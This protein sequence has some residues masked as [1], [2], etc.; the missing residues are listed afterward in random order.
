MLFIPNSCSKKIKR[1]GKKNKKKKLVEQNTSTLKFFYNNIN[2]MMPKR[3]SL[4]QAISIAVPDIVG[5]CET[6]LG[7]K[8]EPKIQ[9]YETIYHNLKQGKEGLLVAVRDGTFTSF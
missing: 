7:R 8:S 2:G 4:S 5:L 1:G 6:K 9:G 3:E